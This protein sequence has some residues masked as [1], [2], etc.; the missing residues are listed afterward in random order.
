MKNILNQIIDIILK[1]KVRL[2]PNKIKP[3]SSFIAD[4]GFDSLEVVDLVIEL[5]DEFNITLDDQDASKITTLQDLANK[6][7]ELVDK[8]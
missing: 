6:V 1:S 4:L 7:K 3:E 5:E 2:D 8:K